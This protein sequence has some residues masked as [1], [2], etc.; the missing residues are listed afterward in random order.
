MS[1][2]YLVYDYTWKHIY[3]S[4]SFFKKKKFSNSEICPRV[5]LWY[6]LV[7]T[8]RMIK[9]EDTVDIFIMRIHESSLAHIWEK[10]SYYDMHFRIVKDF[11]VNFTVLGF[12]YFEIAWII[13]LTGLTFSL[14]VFGI[15]YI[16]SILQ[17]GIS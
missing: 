3:L 8:T 9:M 4:Q 2:G 1:K 17:F 13:L 10:L 11:E 15:E 14:L 5:G 7:F 6:P 12:K 16:I